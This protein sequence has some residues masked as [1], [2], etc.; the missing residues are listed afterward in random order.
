MDCGLCHANLRARNVCPG[1]R[2][3][4]AL[5][6]KSCLQ[7]PIKNCAAL[8]AGNYQFC[9]ECDQFPCRHIKHIDKRYRSRY[10]MSMIENLEAIQREGIHTFVRREQEK[11]TCPGCGKTI[12]VHKQTCMFCGFD[13][14]AALGR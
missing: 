3:E 12:C 1:C 8:I 5:K 9:F 13:W 6:S 4:D 14:R 10:A 11:W 7:C 2:G